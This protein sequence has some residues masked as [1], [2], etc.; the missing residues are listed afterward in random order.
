MKLKGADQ[1]REFAGKLSGADSKELL[2]ILQAVEEA[3]DQKALEASQFQNHLAN[4]ARLAELG[5]MAA[6]VFHEMNQPLLGIKGFA[7][8][9][10]E[11]FKKGDTQKLQEWLTEIRSQAGR[12]QEMQK[13]V[14]N[15]LRKEEQPGEPISLK[16]ALEQALRL[17][18]HRLNKKKIKL[19]VG[20]PDDLPD[21]QVSHVQLIQILVNL[22][23]N[24]VDAIDSHSKGGSLRV[25]AALLPQTGM[26]R[27]L[28]ADNGPGIP[29]NLQEKVFDPFFTTKGKKGTGLG[30]YIARSLAEANG[31]D[32]TLVDPKS[33]GWK[34]APSTV[35]E[36]I[37]P[38]IHPQHFEDGK[39]RRAA[40]ALSELGEGEE[41]DTA[42]HRLAAAPAKP[43][44]FPSEA[45]ADLNT[46]LMEFGSKLHV[47]KRVL[48]VDDEPVILRVLGEFLAQQNI[49]ADAVASAEEAISQMKLKEY[50]VLLTDKNLPGI[51]G[52]ELLKKSKEA[53]PQ[54][55]VVVITGYASVESALDAIAAGAFDYIPKPFPSLTYVSQKTRGAM[56]RHDFE[57]RV[58]AMIDF[59]KDAFKEML[60][61]L[62][63]EGKAN[64][65]GRLKT[66]LT[67]PPQDEGAHIVVVG[68]ASLANSVEAA[69][70]RVTQVD[71]I[72]SVVPA[73]SE[74][75]VNVVVYAESEEGPEGAEAIQQI[76]GINPNV[77]VFIIAK[78]G[79]LSRI[80]S[81]IGIG[82]GD[83]LVRPLEGR[84][85]FVPRLKRLVERQ[86][87]ILRY[88]NVLDTL[89]KL[90]IDLMTT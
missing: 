77:G 83:Y 63:A 24:A 26:V 88:R 14:G 2:R 62:G 58:I 41:E 12:M 66:A 40:S 1:L 5:I 55:E 33:L 25:A 70:N 35:F 80:V 86:K 44:A 89:K 78:E 3:F 36:I 4:A 7:E 21:L 87:R 37:L 85:L 28:M 52:I 59:L 23:G 43:K 57:V 11:N 17:F 64:W 10:L 75:Q 34:E 67:D 65:V 81:A 61:E 71:D 56:A 19:G 16:F 73:V 13:N 50:A 8:L 31:G 54:T 46:R 45:L 29:D 22:V 49:L 82:V 30:L 90:N 47:T 9:A 72:A 69:G 76:H 79:D 51:D 74:Q 68:P 15:F 60:N 48:V 53:W 84:E 18:Q 38:S 32:L 27:I 20:L 6:S 39:L 42:P